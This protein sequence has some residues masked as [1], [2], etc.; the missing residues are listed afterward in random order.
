MK[1]SR[2]SS[3]NPGNDAVRG[4]ADRLSA[5]R[6]FIVMEVLEKALAL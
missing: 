1:Q 6:P 4:H 5:L 2:K 3:E